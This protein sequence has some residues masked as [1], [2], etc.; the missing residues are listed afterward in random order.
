[1]PQGSQNNFGFSSAEWNGMPQDVWRKNPHTSMPGKYI[2]EMWL[3][4]YIQ[5]KFLQVFIY[6]VLREKV[7]G[8]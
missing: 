8:I 3:F 5:I 7:Q 6:Y 2:T 1:M 4:K